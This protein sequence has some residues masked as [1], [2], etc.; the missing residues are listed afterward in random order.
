MLS[1]MAMFI[2]DNLPVATQFTGK[3]LQPI[4]S[5]V[6]LFFT[7]IERKSSSGMTSGIRVVSFHTGL[8]PMWHERNE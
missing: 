1:L 4:I 2:K 6:T 3:I 8:N 7:E 5:E